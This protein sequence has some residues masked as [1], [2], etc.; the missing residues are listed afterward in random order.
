MR[1]KDP[2]FHIFVLISMYPAYHGA[3]FSKNILL[4]NSMEPILCNFSNGGCS[5]ESKFRNN[6]FDPERYTSDRHQFGGLCLELCMHQELHPGYWSEGHPGHGEI[7][8]EGS[9]VSSIKLVACTD[10]LDGLQ[11]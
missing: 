4:K 3:V 1:D 7:D 5:A 11:S 10:Y 9:L 6:S 2:V 8:C